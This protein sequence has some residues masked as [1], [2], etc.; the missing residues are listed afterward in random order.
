MYVCVARRMR[1][2]AKGD[3][4][5]PGP[6]ALCEI[7]Y[8][9]WCVGTCSDTVV[10]VDGGAANTA[11]R[12]AHHTERASAFLCQTPVELFPPVVMEFKMRRETRMKKQRGHLKSS[13]IV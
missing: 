10:A 12:A 8:V 1:P 6:L 2:V 7:H 3:G 13:V 9:G 11:A 5:A 4:F